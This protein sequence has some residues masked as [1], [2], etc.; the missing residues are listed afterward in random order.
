MALRADVSQRDDWYVGETKTLQFT[1]WSDKAKTTA[2]D[3]TGWTLAYDFYEDKSVAFTLTSGGGD[4]TITDATNGVLNV[5]VPKA[6]TDALT[7]L[8]NLHHVLRRTDA[9]NEA[10]LSTGDVILNDPVEV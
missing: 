8:R 4:I 9:G 2:E 1:I 6:K 7:S 10:I 3:I 5:V